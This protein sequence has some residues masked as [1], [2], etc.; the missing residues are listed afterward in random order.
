[1]TEHQFLIPCTLDQLK[2]LNTRLTDLLHK[3]YKDLQESWMEEIRLIASELFVNIVRY[4]GLD[5]GEQV[6]IR[7]QMDGDQVRLWFFDRGVAWDPATSTEGVTDE[8]RESGYGLFLVSTLTD[9]FEY[10]RREKAEYPNQLSIT[11]RLPHA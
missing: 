5:A 3:T 8:L 11:K 4:A 6:L 9:H 2:G 10:H 1:M 7:L